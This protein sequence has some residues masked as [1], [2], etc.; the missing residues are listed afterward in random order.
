[1]RLKSTLT[2]LFSC[3]IA[4]VCVAQP[5]V[6]PIVPLN[7]N[8]VKEIATLLPDS[9]GGVICPTYKDRAVWEYLNATAPKKVKNIT[10]YAER[11]LEKEFPA[12]DNA[13]YMYLYTN[14][15]SDP[16]KQLLNERFRAMYSMA[17]AEALE[18][19]GRYTQKIMQVFDSIAAQETWVYPRNYR[20]ETAGVLVELSVSKAVSDIALAVHMMDDKLPPEFRK[21]VL[22]E[23]YK[24]C[25]N[26]MMSAL[27]NKGKNATWLRSTSNWNSYCLQGITGAALTLIPDK[28]ERA[29]YVAMAERYIQNFVS[30]F[31]P[32]GYCSEGLSYYSMGFGSYMMLREIIM[33]ATSGKLDIFRDNPNIINFALFPVR[34][35]ITPKVCPAIGDCG[36]GAQIPAFMVGYMNKV[37]GL[38][39]PSYGDYFMDGAGNVAKTFLSSIPK[40]DVKADYLA[41]D[42]K[43]DMNR[44]YFNDAGVLIVRNTPGMEPLMGAALKGGNNQ[45]HHNHNDLG[46]FTIAIGKE[47][48]IEDPGLVNY[49]AKTFGPE[50]YTIKILASYGHPVPL[51]AGKE[52]TKGMDS[53]ATITR[54]DFT[55]SKDMFNMEYSSAYKENVPSLESLERDFVFTRGKAPSLEVTDK[56]AFTSPQEFETAI[57]TRGEWKQLAPDKL[58]ITKGG[59]A[60]TV[61]IKA[62]KGV[63]FA[64]SSERID[65]EPNAKLRE[66]RA[67][68]RIAVKLDK[69]LDKGEI[70]I[71]YTYATP[72]NVK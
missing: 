46:T 14:G 50:R 5:E 35:E 62:P 56:F 26:T 38:G 51:V 3:L 64:L 25:F 45:E 8:R 7:M 18:N 27:D 72:K 15:S 33:Q 54:A 43:L 12:W 58:E 29:K 52:Q 53:R 65:E 30:G 1:M 19:K 4:A 47:R 39:L 24:R 48:V 66:Q 59:E 44:S 68:T 57:I 22:D 60:L 67:F 16:G 37:L 34:M 55:P 10:A 69:P 42:F 70:T 63:N 6:V 11:V 32:D 41:G 13:T 17:F 40:Y 28:M 23:L 9:P 36:S 21:K 2:T 71:T 20:K 31:T 49:S 61:V